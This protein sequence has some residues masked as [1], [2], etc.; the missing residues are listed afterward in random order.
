MVGSEMESSDGPSKLKMRYIGRIPIRN[1]WLLM[2]YASDLF[3]IRGIGKVGLEESPDDLPDLIA[4]ILAYTVEKRVRRHLSF[5]YRSRE[6]VLNRVRGRIDVLTTERHKLLLRGKVAC[7]FDELSID[8]PRN[9]FVRAGLE[10]I[11]KIVIR[12]EIAHRCRVLGKNLE[13][14]GVSFIAPTRYE[15]SADRFGLHDAD[16]RMMVAA[17]KLAFNL[18]M[19]TE[20]GETESLILPFYEEIWVRRLFEKAIGGFY[21]VVL[22]PNEWIVKTGQK[23]FWQKE[24]ETSG[25][26]KIFPEM[27]TD[28]IL[29]HKPTHRRIVIDTKFTSILARGQY[30]DKTLHS[31]Y[32]YQIYTYL[33][34][35]VGNGNLF[36]DHASGLLLHPSLGENIDETV[37]IQGHEIRFATVDLTSTSKEIRSQLLGLCNPVNFNDNPL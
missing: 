4:E 25:I 37:L 36:T 12:P 35:Q 18:L 27:K 21:S 19:P 23:L 3:R 10:K 32:I 28:I 30:R 26:D 7:Q 2:L 34:S 20:T 31:G 13:S 33:H 15:M 17:A 16:D 5:G 1:I 8:T 24:K 22:N 29:D 11:S 9:R 6:S 14:M